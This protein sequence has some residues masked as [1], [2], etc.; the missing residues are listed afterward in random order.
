M[1]MK[2]LFSPIHCKCWV[3]ITRKAEGN[4]RQIKY[5]VDL[6]SK[7]H[8][9]QDAALIYYRSFD[10]VMDALGHKLLLENL[11]TQSVDCIIRKTNPRMQDLKLLCEAKN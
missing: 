1:K 3:Y 11:S 5:T 4:S 6:N 9:I 7:L 10:N 8:G 2:Q